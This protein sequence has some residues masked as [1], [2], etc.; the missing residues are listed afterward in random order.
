MPERRPNQ[1]ARIAAVVALVAVFTVVALTVATAG[2]DSGGGRDSGTGELTTTEPNAQGERA[3]E[4]GYYVVKEGDTLAQIAEN[5]G[6]DL[7]NLQE[8][9]PGLDPQ[10]LTPGEHVRLSATR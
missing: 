4:K 8:L 2:N 7:E 10:V 9:N 1:I 3:L 5:T 6:L